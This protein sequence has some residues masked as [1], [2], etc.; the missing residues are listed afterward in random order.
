[1]GR[2][3]FYDF[4]RVEIENNYVNRRNQWLCTAGRAAGWSDGRT[5]GRRWAVTVVRAGWWGERVKR[6]PVERAASGAKPAR[7]RSHHLGYRVG[8]RGRRSRS[9][10]V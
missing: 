7:T 8:R 6:G 10:V 1:M 4:V 3:F 9:L 5:D 2:G